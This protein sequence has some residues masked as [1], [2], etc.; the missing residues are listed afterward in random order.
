MTRTR[1][2]RLEIGGADG[3]GFRISGK[4]GFHEN[5]KIEQLT[6]E[7]IKRG[8]K[9]VVFDFSGLTSLGGGV[10]RI[11]RG[12]AGEMA[13]AGGKVTFVVTSSVVLDFLQ[14]GETPIDI[15]SS[16]EEAVPGAAAAES[17]GDSAKD[18]A[19]GRVAEGEEAPSSETTPMSSPTSEG[20]GEGGGEPATPEAGAAERDGVILMAYDAG[21]DAAAEEESAGPAAEG[22]SAG[23]G[24]P[25]EEQAAE[26]PQERDAEQPPADEAGS[27]ERQEAS[28]ETAR[29]EGET[30]PA[31]EERGGAA[32]Q[33]AP[34]TR[35]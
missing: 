21:D 1:F 2:E 33:S 26:Q 20:A 29:S 30:A 23:D 14:D 8:F 12:F 25:S 15:C 22:E 5:E 3:T 9:R 19:G 16:M 34:P 11:L 13:E 6:R 10:A 18:A 32:A 27:P 35:R 17:A 28:G 7:C 31:R 24:V 4:L